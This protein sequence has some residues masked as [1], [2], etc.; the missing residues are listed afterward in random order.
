[1]STKYRIKISEGRILGP[2]LPEQFQELYEKGSIDLSETVQK[3]PNGDW[4]ELKKFPE[5][6]FLFK[7]SDPTIF[8]EISNLKKEINKEEKEKLEFLDSELEKD[9][10]EFR[11]GAVEEVEEVIEEVEKTSEISTTEIEDN[12]NLDKTRIQKRPENLNNK[13]IEKTIVRK[14][15]DFVEDLSDGTEAERNTIIAQKYFND[16]NRLPVEAEGSSVTDFS[17]KKKIEKKEIDFDESTQMLNINDVKT[18][19]VKEVQKAEKEIKGKN[20]K[21]LPPKVEVKTIEAKRDLEEEEKKKKKKKVFQITVALVLVLAVMEI[22]FPDKDDS[23][24]KI[25]RPQI[26][27]PVVFQNENK[28]QSAELLGKGNQALFQGGYLGR[29]KAS[30]SYRSAL[31]NSIDNDQALGKLVYVYGSLLKDS[32]NVFNDSRE[33]AKLIQLAD[34]K[35]P[36]NIDYVIGTA[37]FYNEIE[38]PLSARVVI[39]RYIRLKKPISDELLITY[40]DSLIKLGDLSESGKVFN[41]LNSLKEKS[42]AVYVSL[43]QYKFFVD[44]YEGA[45]KIL[46][47]GNSIHK[48]S[49]EILSEYARFSLFKEDFKRLYDITKSMEL[50]KADNSI[51]YY[52]QL[53]KFN[54]ILAAVAGKNKAS[55][56]FFSKSLKI[57]SDPELRKKLE[58]L[59]ADPNS[60]KELTVFINENKTIRYIDKSK[61]A[62]QNDDL[63]EALKMAILAKDLN[64]TYY[65]AIKQLSIVQRKRGHFLNA[66]SMLDKYIKENPTNSDP[67]FDLIETYSSARKFDAAKRKLGLFSKVSDSQERRYAYALGKLYMA[68]GNLLPAINWLRKAINLDPLNDHVLF[69]MAQIYLKGGKL[70]QAR[71]L[72]NK[73]IELNPGDVYYRSLYGQTLFEID[74]VDVAIGYVRSQ[75][76]AFSNHPQLIGDIAK[77]Y[78]R[79]GQ[80]KL[81]DEQLE[82]LKKLPNKTPDLFRTLFDSALLEGDVKKTIEYGKELMVVAPGDLE[83]KINFAEFLITNKEYDLAFDV[84][85]DIKSRLN[86]YPR[87]FLLISKIFLIKG[88]LDKAVEMAKRESQNNPSLP[89]VF[90]LIGDIFIKKDDLVQA[91]ANYEKAQ[92]INPDYYDSLYGLGYVNYKLGRYDSSLQLLQKASQLKDNDPLLTRQLGYVYYRL[93]QRDLAK[94]AFKIYLNLDPSAKDRNEIKRILR[95]L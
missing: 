9:H 84:L 86:T 60:K 77:Y 23:E 3:F 85:E 76:E 71:S 45:A 33:L 58:S 56:D 26:T 62:L 69:L 16:K 36:N 15:D 8:K 10:Q 27:Y 21:V 94:E 91:K 53:L 50:L 38:R 66:I 57:K 54:G 70:N 41:K 31:E 68:Q 37:R 95:S 55:I 40:L 6:D 24:F 64:P 13:N 93:G 74:G 43:S 52:S 65:P 88:D 67:V 2:L 83:T 63:N 39:E 28:K 5:L 42:K 29:I 48:N 22:L 87:L 72:I 78:Y 30:N 11:P 18:Q 17:T 73:A 82:R 79:S 46:E 12:P 81:F 44:D 59:E 80:V 7:T 47:E 14:M 32:I 61:Q 1:M 34:K 19:L 20:S 90:V 49:I 51:H 25:I 89:E 92:S 4:K 35:I 75:L